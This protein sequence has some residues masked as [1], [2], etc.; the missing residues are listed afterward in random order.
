LP[1]QDSFVFYIGTAYQCK[2]AG[3]TL[4]FVQNLRQALHINPTMKDLISQIG[5]QV[6]EQ[7]E[8]PPPPTIQEQLTQE[9]A[10]L[11]SIV[12]TMLSIGNTAQAAQILESY[13]Q[14]NPTDP[15]IETLRRRIQ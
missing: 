1:E 11:K 14:V 8:A 7:A 3:N 2:D 12:K 6:K 5:E 4:G 15:E 13:A 9:T 10:K